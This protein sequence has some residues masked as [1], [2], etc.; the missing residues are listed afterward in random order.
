M[1]QEYSRKDRWL[2]G[3]MSTAKMD[4]MARRSRPVR[5][6]QVRRIKQ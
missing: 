2:T 6:R 4:R 5:S 3:M 1:K